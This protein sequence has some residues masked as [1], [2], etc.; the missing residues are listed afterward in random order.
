MTLAFCLAFCL[1]AGALIWLSSKS[2]LG[3]LEFRRFFERQISAKLPNFTPFATVIAPCRGVDPGLAANLRAVV[4]QDYPEYEIIFVLDDIKDPAVGVIS[5]ILNLNDRIKL[6]IA[7]RAVDSSQK[8]ENLRTAV[9]SA[10]PQSKLF[11]FVDSDVRPSPTWLRNLA[12]AIVDDKVG[13]ATGYR[14]FISKTPTFAS[15]LRSSWNASIASA[16][17]S[18]TRSNF[19]WGGSMAI[20][21]D[22]FERLEIRE[23]WVGT[24]SDDFAVTRAVTAAG[25]PIVFVPAAL[26]ASPG[27]CTF[28]DMLEFTTR[29]MKITRVYARDLWFKSFLGSFLFLSVMI[30]SLILAAFAD[31]LFLQAAA[32]LILVAVSAFSVGKAW[33]RLDAVMLSMVDHAVDLK[34]QRLTQCSYWLISPAVFFYNS[35]A[36]LISR[37][38]KWRGTTYELKSPSETVI[39]S[40]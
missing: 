10:D 28:F 22:V 1:L 39:I 12:A 24:L 20:R 27:E 2:Y 33:V 32:L 25:M 18:N 4:S 19:C 23:K 11:A 13:A 3:G 6:V 16:L 34:R 8:V 21:R 29:Q 17:G 38:I 37:R 30:A 40:D 5:D 14:W 15:E 7:P 9:L 36:A 26:T 35:V 31:G